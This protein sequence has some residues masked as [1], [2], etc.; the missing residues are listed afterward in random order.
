MQLENQQKMFIDDGLESNNNNN[1]SQHPSFIMG[2]TIGSQGW[3]IIKNL[4]QCL[5]AIGDAKEFNIIHDGKGFVYISYRRVTSTTFPSPIRTVNDLIRRELRGLA[6]DSE[7]KQL[8]SRC[9]HKFFNVDEKEETKMERVQQNLE[10]S[11]RLGKKMHVLDKLDGSLVIPILQKNAL[12]EKRLR[13]RT[14]QGFGHN[15]TSRGCEKHIYGLREVSDEDYE[16]HIPTVDEF[17]KSQKSF[18]FGNVIQFCLDY[19]EKGMTPIFEFCSPDYKIVIIY[20]APS[21]NL[22]ALRDTFNGDYVDFDEMTLIAR[23]YGM[24]CVKATHFDFLD[25]TTCT[26]VSEIISEIK[27][28]HDFEGCVLRFWNGEMYKV[29]SDWYSTMHFKKQRLEFNFVNESH[30]WWLVLEGGIDDLIP[31]LNTEE[32]KQRLTAFNDRLGLTL[33]SFSENLR[34]QV[35]SILEETKT[36]KAFAAH[37]NTNFKSVPCMRKL[38]FDVAR[39]MTDQKNEEENTDLDAKV[40]NLVKEVLLRFVSQNKIEDA[41]TFL[42]D[43]TLTYQKDFTT[44]K[45]SAF[46]EE[47]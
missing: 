39:L 22:I 7:T 15:S 20:E 10:H 46:D 25:T 2:T 1:T 8:V 19:I 36:Q 44:L 38:M 14:K 24:D 13:F 21:L 23:E 18:K 42:R 37:L 16:K 5:E 33:D 12:N 3:P 11:I 9:L 41:R 27:K 17:L 28:K 29:K 34:K 31:I 40:N 35:K 26:S 6:F 30:A 47:E 32:E 4:N 45:K 43:P